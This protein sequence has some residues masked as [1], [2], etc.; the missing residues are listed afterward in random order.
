MRW[1]TSK[2]EAAS[3]MVECHAKQCAR[4]PREPGFERTESWL[5]SSVLMRRNRPAGAVRATDE[6]SKS[7]PCL[8]VGG[9][10]VREGAGGAPEELVHWR[11]EAHVRAHD[12]RAV[13]VAQVFFRVQSSSATF[14]T[15]RLRAT[16]AGPGRCRRE[17]PGCL[18]S[19]ISKRSALLV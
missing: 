9:R 13:R 11:A 1:C 10:E 16:G 14:R 3:N 5:L 17:W 15:D 2:C 6:V 4:S 19:Q 12:A 18:G 7:V 8:G